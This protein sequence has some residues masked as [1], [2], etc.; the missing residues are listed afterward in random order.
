MAKLLDLG[1]I[2][3][4][5]GTLGKTKTGE[6]TIWAEEL[7]ML[8]KATLPPPSKWHGLQDVELR[9]RQRYVDLFSNPEV[10]KT[11]Q[12]RAANLH[13]DHYRKSG[14]AVAHLASEVF[15]QLNIA[16]QTLTDPRRQVAGVIELDQQFAGP[17]RRVLQP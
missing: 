10:M 12:E 3:G 7:T 6:I 14:D 8:S 9:Y 17:R 5:K 4:V 16:Y 15:A 2:I 13:P 11:F 1:D